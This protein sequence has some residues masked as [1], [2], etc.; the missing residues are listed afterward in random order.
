MKK[1][2]DILDIELEK[3]ETIL[4]QT[5]MENSPYLEIFKGKTELEY[6]TRD[7]TEQLINPV[8]A[9]SRRRVE[10]IFEYQDEIKKAVKILNQL[11]YKMLKAAKFAGRL[12]NRRISTGRI[13]HLLKVLLGHTRPAEITRVIDSEEY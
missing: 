4:A 12:K 7:I 11:S 9:Y 1:R 10:V 3:I 5:T 8:K 6:M 13:N 2:Y